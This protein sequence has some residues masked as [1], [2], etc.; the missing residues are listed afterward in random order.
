MVNKIHSV[1]LEKMFKD[2]FKKKKTTGYHDNYSK[3]LMG[4]NDFV[5]GHPR[6]MCAK[7][8]PDCLTA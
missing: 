3:Q 1:V 6:S 4:I 7:L 2:L 8:S 5:E